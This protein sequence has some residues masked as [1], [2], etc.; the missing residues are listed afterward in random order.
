MGSYTDVSASSI[1]PL[2]VA[3]QGFTQA[4]TLA[5]VI[6]TAL[7]QRG[8]DDLLSDI[9]WLAKDF[10]PKD[11][12]IVTR[13]AGRLLIEAGPINIDDPAERR[14][15]FCFGRMIGPGADKAERRE[16]LFLQALDFGNE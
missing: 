1:G 16:V 10:A 12:S 4:V 15:Q 14:H 11:L 5:A 13:I 6:S 7:G 2:T 9:N 8:S 3:P